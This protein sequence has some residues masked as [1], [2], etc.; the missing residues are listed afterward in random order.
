MSLLDNATRNSSYHMRTTYRVAARPPS[1]FGENFAASWDRMQATFR[2]GASDAR[3]TGY[4]QNDITAYENLTGQPYNPTPEEL[5]PYTVG[6]RF[7]DFNNMYRLDLQAR[8]AELPPEQQALFNFDYEGRAGAEAQEIIEHQAEVAAAATG[9]GTTGA[10]LGGLAGGAWD[11]TVLVISALGG[12]ALIGRAVGAG[13]AILFETAL[14]AA[15]EAAATPQFAEQERA[16]GQEFTWGDAVFNIVMSGVGSGAFAGALRGAG[17]L[18]RTAFPNL[19]TRAFAREFAAA[20]DGVEFAPA[21]RM[22]ADIFVQRLRESEIVEPTTRTVPGDALRFYSALDDATASVLSGRMIDPQPFDIPVDYD[23]FVP[24]IAARVAAAAEAI[25]D[26]TL[27][28]DFTAAHRANTAA[29]FTEIRRAEEAIAAA[30]RSPAAKQAAERLQA[31]D[32]QLGQISANVR[33]LE[34]LLENIDAPTTNR[35][36]LEGYAPDRAALD[37]LRDSGDTAAVEDLRPQLEEAITRDIEGGRQQFNDLLETRAGE[38]RKLRRSPGL[39]K[40][41]SL[42]QLLDR[43]TSKT[44]I[45]RQGKTKVAVDGPETPQ[46]PW[47]TIVSAIK[48]EL[49]ET[50]EPKIVAEIQLLRKTNVREMLEAS[51]NP[52]NL[53][54][55]ETIEDLWKAGKNSREIMA[56]L[57]QADEALTDEEILPIIDL[58]KSDIVKREYTIMNP[59]TG[60]RKYTNEELLRELDEDADALRQFD[61]CR[62]VTASG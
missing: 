46:T 47:K 2:I 15:I 9:G 5:A 58:V 36:L 54:L 28:A 32:T 7:L 17:A 41:D 56:A 60:A 33:A 61:A 19:N 10:V 21:E 59:E 42:R 43:I 53:K 23:I 62:G 12:A 52:D 3:I 4:I 45:E 57:R 26:P 34:D 29:M 22:A 48:D 13:R 40:D 49:E 18:A 1:Y 30:A 51:T 25:A 6:Q 55:A 35:E 11:P 8:V 20:L 50:V 24:N 39:R 27:R 38:A 14:G 31:I 37:R 44:L 16:A